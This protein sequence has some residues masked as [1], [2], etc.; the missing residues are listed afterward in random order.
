MKTVC[1]KCGSDEIQ[2]LAEVWLKMNDWDGMPEDFEWVDKYW[3]INCDFDCTP[4]EVEHPNM[5][6]KD[7]EWIPKP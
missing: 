7:G 5:I 6:L 2:Q 1:E 3:C 4:K